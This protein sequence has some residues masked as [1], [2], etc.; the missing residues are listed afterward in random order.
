MN[1]SP[2]AR[3]VRRAIFICALAL[4]VPVF[5]GLV[6]YAKPF[7]PLRRTQTESLLSKALDMQVE[8]KGPVLIG[9]GWAPAVALEDIV[10]M[11]SG[12]RATKTLSVKS[13]RGQIPLAALIAGEAPLKGL[14]VDGLHL[15][16]EIPEGRDENEKDGV[17][18]AATVRDFVRLPFAGDFLVRNAT[19]DYVNHDSEFDLRCALDEIA[20]RP[21]Q[22]GGVTVAANGRLN[23][24]AWK[25]DANVDPPGS[26][27]AERRFALAVNTQ[28][29][30]RS[31]QG[32]I[33]STRA[34]FKPAKTQS[35]SPRTRPSRR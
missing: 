9:F 15:A 25:L 14:V 6:L 21:A 29:S 30:R 4:S 28:G 7:D 17:D 35:T 34:S 13:V 8:V 5:A 1:S 23:D 32:R 10:A 20:S 2:S 27:E 3:R 22:D 18:I 31:L 24:E 12:P 26:D 11:E 19:V 16:V 33:L